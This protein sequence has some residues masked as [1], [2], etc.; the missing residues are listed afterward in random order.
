MI[1]C[2]SPHVD[3]VILGMGGT[4]NHFSP[5]EIHVVTFSPARRS[6][7]DQ[8][9]KAQECA[10]FQEYGI[11]NIEILDFPVRE[12]HRWRSDIR[13][14]LYQ[15]PSFERIYFPAPGD[16]HQDHEVITTE[17]QRVMRSTTMLGYIHPQNHRVE[18]PT[19]FE[20]LTE[21]DLQQQQN[22]AEHYHGQW[23]K[24]YFHRLRTKAKFYGMKVFQKYA[25][26]FTVERV[27]V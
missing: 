7:P 2:L 8:D 5:D 1:L 19:W 12:F 4:L 24:M 9:T 17:T 27:I 18:T 3:D 14:Y 23:H 6:N 13:E 11:T 21:D 25:E 20:L 22:A 10:A 15:L 26:A 16:T